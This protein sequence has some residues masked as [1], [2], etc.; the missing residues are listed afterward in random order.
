MNACTNTCMVNCNSVIWNVC[1]HT[2]MMEEGPNRQHS[3][4]DNHDVVGAHATVLELLL[5]ICVTN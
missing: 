1:A 4:V 3:S 5:S 2:C